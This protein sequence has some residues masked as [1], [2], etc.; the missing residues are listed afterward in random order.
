MRLEYLG[1]PRDGDSTS[2]YGDLWRPQVG[3]EIEINL[4]IR[5]VY[6]VE[7]RKACGRGGLVLRLRKS[8]RPATEVGGR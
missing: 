6:R 3:Q 4:M 5:Y 7:N 8:Y 2:V 1:G